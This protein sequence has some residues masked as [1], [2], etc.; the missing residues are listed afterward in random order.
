[1][2]KRKYTQHQFLNFVEDHFLKNPNVLVRFDGNQRVIFEDGKVKFG[3]SKIMPNINDDILHEICHII[4]CQYDELKDLVFG[5]NKDGDIEFKVHALSNRIHELANHTQDP[6]SIEADEFSL[7]CNYPKLNN[8]QFWTK[9]AKHKHNFMN[10]TLNEI[11]ENFNKHIFLII[12]Y[13][14]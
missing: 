7:R 2:K 3:Y 1:M 6:T 12:N 8:I 11:V 13:N 4:V 10:S 9:Q 14:Q 5:E